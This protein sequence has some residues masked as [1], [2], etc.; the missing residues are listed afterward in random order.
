MVGFVNTVK[1]GFAAKAAFDVAVLSRLPNAE[2]AALETLATLQW[3]EQFENLL[4]GVT[5]ANENLGPV[6]PADSAASRAFDDDVT[7]SLNR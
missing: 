7:A 1:D 6:A 5:P 3:S 2:R 4:H